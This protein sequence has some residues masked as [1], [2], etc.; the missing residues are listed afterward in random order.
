MRPP[1]ASAACFAT[2]R[3]RPIPWS[4]PVTNGSNSFAAISAGGP[5][6]VS[7]TSHHAPRSASRRQ[8]HL[9]RPRPGRRPRPRCRSRSEQV[10]QLRRVAGDHAR[11][12][13]RFPRQRR[14][15][16]LALR[17]QQ[18]HRLVDQLR[19]VA[20]LASPRPAACRGR[21][22]AAG[23]PRSGRVAA[24][25][26]AAAPGRRPGSR[27]GTVRPPASPRRRRCGVGAPARRRT[28]RAPAAARP[29]ASASLE[30]G[31]PAGHVVDRP[32][33]VARPRRPAAGS[34]IGRKSPAAMSRVRWSR[35]RTR[36][37]SR[38]RPAPASPTA[39]SPP[40]PPSTQ[41]RP[42]R[43]PHGRPAQRLG[44]EDVQV[45]A[46]VRVRRAAAAAGSGTRSRRPSPAGRGRWSSPPR[47]G[48]GGTSAGGGGGRVGEGGDRRAV[49]ADE[50]ELGPG[51]PL[52]LLQHPLGERERRRLGQGAGDGPQ[53]LGEPALGGAGGGA[54]PPTPSPPGRRAAAASA[55]ASSR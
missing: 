55:A 25:P 17:P 12:G 47:R 46:R 1:C 21:G 40:T 48:R 8:R 38:G 51:E 15:G 54:P 52:H 23:S 28:A 32:A 5:G 35:S 11:P 34:G 29:A 49:A 2:A 30:L 44:V 4:F 9:D 27:P 53:L 24:A 39:T 50:Q 31:E 18:A 7:V 20:R 42:G 6:P 45:A 13:R 14:P 10:P 26:P 41:Q 36:R 33:Q 3:P 43:V 22:T 19:Q 16:V 37:T